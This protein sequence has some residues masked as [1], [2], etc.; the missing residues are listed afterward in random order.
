METVR[1]CNFEAGVAVM[2]STIALEAFLPFLPLQCSRRLLQ[3]ELSEL[4]QAMQC[5]I[6]AQQP[7]T[8]LY[9]DMVV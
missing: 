8:V 6:L 3:S 4:F 1:Y 7:Y 5:P 9:C 2:Y